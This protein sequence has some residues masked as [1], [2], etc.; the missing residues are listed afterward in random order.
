MEHRLILGGSQWLPFARSRIKALRQ[1]GLVFASQ[2][3][4]MPDGANV[5]VWIGPLVEYIRIDGSSCVERMDSGLV[6]LR[7]ITPLAPLSYKAGTLYE[8]LA[9]ATYN[10]KFSVPD[11]AAPTALRVDKA[12]RPAHQMSGTVTIT[13]KSFAGAVQADA[14]P[15]N[16]FSPER[17]VTDATTSPP[18]WRYSDG[19]DRLLAK[20]TMALSCPP[21]MFTGRARLYVQALYG[22]HLHAYNDPAAPT[23][24]VATNDNVTLGPQDGNGY[25][26]Y[27]AAYTRKDDTQA[28]P[29][30]KIN[31]STGVYFHPATGGHTL[32]NIEQGNIAAYPLVA[33][34]CG[35]SARKFVVVDPNNPSVLAQDDQDKLEAYIL[36]T[37]RP[38]VKNRT[39]IGSVGLIDTFSSCGYGWHWNWDG[40]KANLVVNKRFSQGGTAE[41]MRSTH[42]ALAVSVSYDPAQPKT[43]PVLTVGVSVVEG[44]IDWS[45]FRQSWCIAEPSWALSQLIKTTPGLSNA[46][47]NTDAPF[48]VF[49]VRNDIQVCRVA[50]TAILA[51]STN[52]VMD[53]PG[54]ADPA[55]HGAVAAITVGARI[56]N[57]TDNDAYSA[58]RQV[59]VKVGSYSAVNLPFSF[60]RTYSTY[61]LDAKIQKYPHVFPSSGLSAFGSYSYVVGY[62]PYVTVGPFYGRQTST[63]VP[64]QWDYTTLD[65]QEVNTGQ[66]AV[67]IPLYDAEAAYVWAQRTTQRSRSGTAKTT[68]TYDPANPTTSVGP[69]WSECWWHQDDVNAAPRQYIRYN[70]VAPLPVG[71]GATLVSSTTINEAL[72]IT[73]Q[74]TDKLLIS[75][76]GTTTINDFGSLATFFQNGQELIPIGFDTR[77]GTSTATPVVIAPGRI[78]AIG[79]PAALDLSTQP[80]I[81]NNTLAALVGWV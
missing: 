32:I 16:S 41:G 39:V 63:S 14:Q 8:T 58:D 37:C 61:V 13:S 68:T 11:G 44:P 33:D 74:S 6:D 24:L 76:A 36:A 55:W 22:S 80:T 21:S 75:H 50:T 43:P 7:S 45:L 9:V 3:F 5:V 20:K 25:S 38:D 28:Y 70:A 31:T 40:T 69:L 42:N 10:A 48:Y 51:G 17:I 18:T 29:S 77:S 81:L 30:V 72:A 60:S 78:Q 19:D 56:G 46:I 4:V 67:A 12:D 47:D 53:P 52:R 64:W 59:T 79:A 27:L 57:A 73:Q 34:P 26:L 54:F 23:T 35:E 71:G 15:A 1:T 65:I 66:F 2:K 49:Y 62:P